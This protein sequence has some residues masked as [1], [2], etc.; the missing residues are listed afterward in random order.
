MPSLKKETNLEGQSGLE[1]RGGEIGSK[2][3]YKEYSWRGSSA[4]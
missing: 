4:G 2:Y 3:A 1:K